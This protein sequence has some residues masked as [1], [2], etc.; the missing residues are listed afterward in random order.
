MHSRAEWPDLDHDSQETEDISDR[1]QGW[2]NLLYW[3]ACTG[4]LLA[5]ATGVKMKSVG[6]VESYWVHGKQVLLV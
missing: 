5:I 6:V 2:C 1:D 4:G 3:K